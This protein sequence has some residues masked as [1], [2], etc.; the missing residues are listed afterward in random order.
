MYY[1]CIIYVLSMYYICIISKSE[2]KGNKRGIKGEP[3][4]QRRLRFEFK[5]NIVEFIQE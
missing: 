2:K 4:A 1:D 3:N 5:R